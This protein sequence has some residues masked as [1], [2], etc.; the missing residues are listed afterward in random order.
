MLL[1][2]LRSAGENEDT[3]PLATG[4][5]SGHLLFITFCVRLI[6]LRVAKLKSYNKRLPFSLKKDMVNC[7]S[8][9]LLISLILECS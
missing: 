9:F 3:A 5:N 6:Y 8:D 4:G 7:H 1:L 2:A